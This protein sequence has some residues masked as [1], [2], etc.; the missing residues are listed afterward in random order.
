MLHRNREP[1]TILKPMRITDRRISPPI[2]WEVSDDAVHTHIADLQNEVCGP[3]AILR[4]EDDGSGYEIVNEEVL[5]LR[6]S[7]RANEEPNAGTE[8]YIDEIRIK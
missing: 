1:L 3:K 4:L 5:K 2:S 6:S 8:D 7:L